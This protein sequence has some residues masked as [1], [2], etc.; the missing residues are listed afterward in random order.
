MVRKNDKKGEKQLKDLTD[1]VKFMPSNFDK[2]EKESL[3]KE[4]R[5]VELESKVVSLYTKVEK[6]GFTADRME[7]CSIHNSILIR[8]LPE[9]K[10]EDTDYLII[11]TAKKKM[12]LDIP[13][14]HIDRIHRIGAPPKQSGKVRPVIVTFVLYND[15]RKI[16]INKGLLKRTEVSITENL[17]AHH[18]EKFCFKNVC[19]NDDIIIYKDNGDD[20]TKIYFDWHFDL[21]FTKKEIK[22]GLSLIA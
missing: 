15:R 13:S 6:L 12:G 4:A 16:Y 7:Q 21:F 8:G 14:A 19:S 5:I 18:V 3:E 2:Y 10:G 9:E 22:I 20:K 1:S 17:T 11:V